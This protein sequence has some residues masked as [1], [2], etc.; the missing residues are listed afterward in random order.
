MYYI[1]LN[2]KHADHICTY[3]EIDNGGLAVE[4]W[5]NFF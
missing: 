3:I 1:L 5:V 2:Y 4:L